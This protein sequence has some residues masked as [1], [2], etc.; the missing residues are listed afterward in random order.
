MRPFVLTV[1]TCKEAGHSRLVLRRRLDLILQR[2]LIVSG[3]MS[4]LGFEAI[5]SQEER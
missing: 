2:E 5:G 4:T 3:T 1:V